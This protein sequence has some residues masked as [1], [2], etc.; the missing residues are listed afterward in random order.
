MTKGEMGSTK[1]SLDLKKYQLPPIMPPEPTPKTVKPP[2]GPN[3]W[4]IKVINIDK[5]NP[6]MNSAPNN[7][8]GRC[9]NSFAKICWTN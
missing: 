9:K 2:I 8:S 7:Q 6:A 3:V 5:T 4:I 1:K